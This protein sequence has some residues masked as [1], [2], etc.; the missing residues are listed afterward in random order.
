MP[1][2][3][4]IAIC[5][6]SHNGKILVA[7]YQ[8]VVKPEIFFRPVGGGIEF[9][10]YAADTIARETM[11]EL[12]AAVRNVH[13]LYTL[14][15]LFV[16]NGAGGHEIVLVFD[17]SFV[18]ASLYERSVLVGTDRDGPYD[19]VWMSRHELELDVRPLY[20]YGLLERLS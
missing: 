12:G 17:G 18:D 7:E 3:R 14:E 15:N 10:E 8:D 9:G 5:L 4:P 19:A 6:F 2:I 11:E 20:P 16:H 13:Y 1:N